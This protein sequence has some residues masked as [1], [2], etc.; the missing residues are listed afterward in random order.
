MALEEAALGRIGMIDLVIATDLKSF[1]HSPLL[2]VIKP[3]SSKSLRLVIVIV[4]RVRFPWS[5]KLVAPLAET[6]LLL[7]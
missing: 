7:S 5:V 2:P 4:H 6:A 3:L 1:I